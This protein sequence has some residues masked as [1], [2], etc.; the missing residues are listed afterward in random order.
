MIKISSIGIIF[1]SQLIFSQTAKTQG[2]QKIPEVFEKAANSLVM[3]GRNS[4]H[5]L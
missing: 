2:Y 4:G 3:V 5:F 1:F